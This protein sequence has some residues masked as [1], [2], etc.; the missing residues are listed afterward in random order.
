MMRSLVLLLLAAPLLVF[1]SGCTKSDNN[2]K[3]K[4]GANAP[5]LKKMTPAGGPGQAP[6]PE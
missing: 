3:I 5:T 4:E 6:K 2:P 1:A